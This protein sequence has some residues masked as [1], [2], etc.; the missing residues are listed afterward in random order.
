M[1]TISFPELAQA[2]GLSLSQRNFDAVRQLYEPPNKPS[3]ALDNILRSHRQTPW[4]LKRA[5]HLTSPSPRLARGNYRAHVCS[6]FVRI[7]VIL[8]I[9]T[10][11]SNR[12]LDVS[13]CCAAS[14]RF[15]FAHAPR[16]RS[17]LMPCKKMDRYSITASAVASGRSLGGREIDRKVEPGRLLDANIRRLK[18]VAPKSA[19]IFW[20]V[21]PSLPA[22]LP[23]FRRAGVIYSNAWGEGAA[24]GSP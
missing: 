21:R 13:R 20:A 19:G 15:E 5:V 9:K 22:T 17:G 18:R 4:K 6:E 3:V 14:R 11:K 8:A 1:L 7:K 2:Q 10:V 23:L 24:T 12:H 16:A